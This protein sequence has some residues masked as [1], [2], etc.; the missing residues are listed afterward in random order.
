MTAV[1]FIEELFWNLF[2]AACFL[3]TFTF[4]RNP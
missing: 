2:M 4:G 3:W 1:T